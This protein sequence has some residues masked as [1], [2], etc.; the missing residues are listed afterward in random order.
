MGKM[1]RGNVPDCGEGWAQVAQCM[2]SDAEWLVYSKPQDHSPDWMTFKIVAK[3]RVPNKANYWLA[4]N[5]TT[6]QIGFCR[7]YVYMRDN[8][9]ELHAQVEEIFEHAKGRRTDQEEA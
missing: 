4:K 9:P 1:Y 8:R 2:D 5:I 7:D 6:G 3:G